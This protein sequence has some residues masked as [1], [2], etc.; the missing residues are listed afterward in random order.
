MQPSSQVGPHTEHLK[1]VVVVVVPC[2]RLEQ[3]IVVNYQLMYLSIFTLK[4]N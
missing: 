3:M 4:F 1:V 2:A